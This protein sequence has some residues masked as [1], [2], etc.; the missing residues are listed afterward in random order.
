MPRLA[1][2]SVVEPAAF[3]RELED[4][5]R[6]E[7]LAL[8]VKNAPTATAAAI[9]NIGVIALVLWGQVSPHLLS[10]WTIA[11]IALNVLRLCATRAY[12]RIAPAPDRTQA[13]ANA[14]AAAI[15]AQ[16]LGWSVA[17]GVFF[18]YASTEARTFIAVM[19]AGMVAG[20]VSVLSPLRNA[21]FA[22][23]LLLVVPEA[24][25]CFQLPHPWPLFGACAMLFVMTQLVAAQ[26]AH[27]RFF[28]IVRTDLEKQHLVASLAEANRALE[29]SRD[30][31]MHG[32]RAKADFLANMSHE[33]RTPMTSIVGYADLL[34]TAEDHT[35]LRDYGAAIQRN[36]THLLTLINDILDLSKIEAGKLLVERI[37][38]SPAEIVA[39]AVDMLYGP[40]HAAGLALRSETSGP[41]PECISSDPVRLRQILVNLLSNAVKFT[42]AGEIRIETSLERKDQEAGL[43]IRVTDTGIGMTPDQLGRIFQ[44]F[45]QADAGIARRY[46]GTGLGLSISRRLAELLG[47]R[48]SATSSPGSGSCFELALG[49]G[50]WDDVAGAR[51]ASRPP[52]R[53]ARHA[54]CAPPSLTGRVLLAEDG[55]DNQRLIR[56]LLE[57]RGLEV[58]IV[59]NGRAAVTRAL[60]ARTDGRPHDLVLMDIQMPELDGAA[61]T[62]ELKAHGYVAPII[63]LTAQA[64]EGDRERFMR[65]GFDAYASKPIA[66]ADLDRLLVRF[67]TR[68]TA[69]HARAPAAATGDATRHGPPGDRVK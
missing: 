40:A 22:W 8:L 48:L 7:M 1:Q 56:V 13:W 28:S 33:I 26:H 64:L 42:A 68:K 11:L 2:S 5:S 9:I 21:T 31:A 17:S 25:I 41:I 55:K 46:G 18:A 3:A 50:P 59:D 16:A 19:L 29:I 44:P 35:Q 39:S 27:D 62:A 54:A 57:R 47:G 4:R 63:A 20:G 58:E 43:R 69:G 24:V 66:V 34:A 38:C 10:T 32:A 45:T 23:I 14:F 53:P 49:L 60:A 36:T 67:L 30:A 12:T 52:E 6:Q 65:A 15:V 51:A 61:A 37:A